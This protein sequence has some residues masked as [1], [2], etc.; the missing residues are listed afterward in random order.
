M[1]PMLLAFAATILIAFGAYFIL[2]EMGFSS[3]ERTAGDAV[4]LGTN[5]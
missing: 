2:G 4:R 1:K 5:E 3:E